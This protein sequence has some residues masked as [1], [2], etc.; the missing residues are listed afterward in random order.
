MSVFN[1]ALKLGTRDK[2]NLKSTFLLC[3]RFYYYTT[4]FLLAKMMDIF[5]SFY[6]I[7]KLIFIIYAHSNNN[8]AAR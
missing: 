4:V 7:T 3:V 5:P 6:I 8:G 2:V 1:E